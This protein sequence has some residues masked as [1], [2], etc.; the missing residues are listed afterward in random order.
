MASME[1]WQ[2]FEFSPSD[3]SVLLSDIKPN[4][5]ASFSPW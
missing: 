5:V 4:E 1:N 3:F 2:K